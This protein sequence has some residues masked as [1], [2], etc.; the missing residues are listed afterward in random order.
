MFK[1]MVLSFSIIG[2]MAAMM[3]FGAFAYF[4]D[5][6]AGGVAITA[7]TTNVQV[8][9]QADC[10]GAWSGPL[11]SFS[12]TQTGIVPGDQT[13]DCFKVKNSGDGVL[14]AYALTSAFGGSSALQAVYQ[15][16]IDGACGWASPNNPQYSAS[17][18]CSLVSNLASGAT[19]GTLYLRT[20]F[21]DDGT[22]QSALQGQSYNFTLS[23]DGYTN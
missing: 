6:A 20:R 14:N 21:Y 23:V 10:T 7:G 22:D 12:I 4:K 8:L 19:S 3:A 17:R 13:L 2:A 18:G 5:S 15:A 9:W 16:Q 11:D 1:R